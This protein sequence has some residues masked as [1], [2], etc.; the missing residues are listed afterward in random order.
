MWVKVSNSTYPEI[1]LP[2]LY[3]KSFIIAIPFGFVLMLPNPKKP[4]NQNKKM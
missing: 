2:Q 1:Y 4:I 3:R